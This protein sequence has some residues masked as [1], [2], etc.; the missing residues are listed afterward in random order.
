MSKK[1]PASAN[2]ANNRTLVLRDQRAMQDRLIDLME[3]ADS[4]VCAFM[5]S[6][7]PMVTTNIESLKKAEMAARKRRVKLRYIADITSNN[8]PY[9][10]EQLNIVDELKHLNGA[11]GNFI[12]SNKEYMAAPSIPIDGPIP[13]AVHSNEGAILKQEKAIFQT[14]WDKAIPAEERIKELTYS[15]HADPSVLDSVRERIKTV[16]DRFY[17][18]TICRAVFI[19]EEEAGQH[20][21]LTGHNKMV[22]FPI[23]ENNDHPHQ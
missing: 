10:E 12:V 15:K 16:I 2:G 7:T 6:V 4:E 11:K 14:L 23:D 8:L 20:R 22:E 17:I 1:T 18:C 13:E 21:I 5:D 19:I 3:S 9:C